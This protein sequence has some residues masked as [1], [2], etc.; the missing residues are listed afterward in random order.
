[1]AGWFLDVWVGYLVSL[2][3]IQVRKR[4]SHRYSNWRETPATILGV[5]WRELFWMERPVVE[6]VYAYHI[7]GGFYGGVDKK[8][9]CFKS[10]AQNYASRFVKG[11]TLIVRVKPGEPEVSVVLDE[12]QEKMPELT[13]T[14]RG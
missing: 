9:F 10:S 2:V 4:R 3:M 11:D 13:K 14:Y 8:P 5:S 1:V 12:D 6:F 7:E